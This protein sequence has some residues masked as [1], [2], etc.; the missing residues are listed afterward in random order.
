MSSANPNTYWTGTT[1][2]AIAVGRMLIGVDPADPAVDVAGET[3][4]AKTH[5]LAVTELPAHTHTQRVMEFAA[6]ALS[7]VVRDTSANT[8]VDDAQQTGATG[9]GAAHNNM[10]P[11]V[12]VHMWQRV[13]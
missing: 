10:P 4:G 11:Y 6:G 13:T 7:G 5:T 1:W 8:V 9:G 2:Q 12:A 3:G